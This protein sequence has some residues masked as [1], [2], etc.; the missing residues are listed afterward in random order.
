M[1]ILRPAGQGGGPSEV[2]QMSGFMATHAALVGAAEFHYDVEQGSPEWFELR[3]GIPTASNF[4]AVMA[5]GRDG[6]ESITRGKLLDR[7]A[8]E[9]LSGELA[10][11]FSNAAMERGKAMEAEAR[12]WYE[13][14]RLANLKPVGFVRRKLPSGRYIGCSPDSEVEGGRGLE[15]KTKTP[16]L[17]VGMLKAGGATAPKEFRAQLQGTLLITGWQS[18][19]LVIFYRGMP[20]NP[21]FTI[22]R[23]QAYITE[24]SSALEVFDFDLRQLVKNI[25]RMA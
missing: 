6:G 3:R 24:L 17:I 8:G 11:T 18:I 23:D 22:I 20:V 2:S 12:A 5:N 14:T 16:E 9:I 7:L 15:I 21:T 19:D 1:P 25:Q 4:A 10:E 13:R